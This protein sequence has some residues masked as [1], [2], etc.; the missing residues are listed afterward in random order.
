M[1]LNEMRWVTIPV[2]VES[3]AGATEWVHCVGGWRRLT[4]GQGF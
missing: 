2:E 4:M 1:L 3:Y